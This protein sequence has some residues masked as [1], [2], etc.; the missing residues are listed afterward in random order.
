MAPDRRDARVAVRIRGLVGHEYP[1]DFDVNL[2]LVSAMGDLHVPQL[3]G[4]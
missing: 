2:D 4:G 3:R 1:R